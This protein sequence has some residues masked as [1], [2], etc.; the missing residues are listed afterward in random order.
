VGIYKSLTDTEIGTV[1]VLFFFGNS[2]LQ[3]TGPVLL[4]RLCRG[5]GISAKD[6]IMSKNRTLYCFHTIILLYFCDLGEY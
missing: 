3:C 2:S 5:E 4:F 6:C 1:A